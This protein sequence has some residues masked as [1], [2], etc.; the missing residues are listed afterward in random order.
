MG[1]WRWLFPTPEDR[2]VRAR[3]HVA[4][5]RAELARLDLLDLV[6]AADRDP[7]AA[8]WAAEAREVLHAAETELAKRNLVAAV[9]YASLHEDDKAQDCLDLAETFHH[10]GLEDQFRDV[11]RQ[12]REIRESRSAEE[13]RARAEQNARLLAVDPLGVT[14]G[15]SW[16]DPETPDVPEDAEE[17]AQRLALL[18]EQ[19]PEALRKTVPAL[20]EPFARAVLA[21]DE[22]QAE[23]ALPILTELPD[24]QPLVW[25]ERA[26]TAHHFGD[27]KATAQALRSF[28]QYAGGHHA[29]GANHTGVY[30][31][32]VLA[33][34]G[35][36]QGGLRVL[37]DV[38]ATRPDVGGFLF[39]QLL[40]ASGALPESEA[41][42]SALIRS[43]PGEP[44]LYTMLARVRVAGQHRVEAMRALEACLEVTCCTPGKC[45]SKAPD[46]ETH[47]MLATL[48]LEDGVEVARGLE[49]AGTAGSLVRQV[50][51]D[52]AY[53]AALAAKVAHQPTAADLARRLRALTPS[54]HPASDRVDRLLT[55]A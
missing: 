21:L 2:I 15:P 47:R 28:A 31:A 22:G 12:M 52:D 29:I 18:I 45:G 5:D 43:H 8:P 9:N 46:L 32:Q 3:E 38:R 7:A 41:V 33:E 49:L 14:G 6:E 40:Y 35:D 34:A 11:R 13:E 30:L 19:Y 51:W 24:D 17:L 23:V 54:G 27:L 37:R 55:T 36:V 16:L 20:G 4:K 53:L 48:Y 1:L 50:S 26:R 39:A 44:A 25:W 42:L 10:G